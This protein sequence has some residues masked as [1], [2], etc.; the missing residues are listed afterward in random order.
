MGWLEMGSGDGWFGE[1]KVGRYVGVVYRE[2]V[3]WMGFSQVM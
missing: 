2:V 1:G 3:D